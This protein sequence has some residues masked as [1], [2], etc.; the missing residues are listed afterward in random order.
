MSSQVVTGNI[1]KDVITS[2]IPEFQNPSVGGGDFSERATKAIY[3]EVVT[4]PASN[5]EDVMIRA[6]VIN[7]V[8]LT[9]NSVQLVKNNVPMADQES[10]APGESLK[11][12]ATV[13]FAD[14][15]DHNPEDPNSTPTQPY[16]LEFVLTKV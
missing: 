13:T 9:V 16:S 10:F 2:E 3:S 6:E 14:T 12:K 11:V 1:N 7:P 15:P 5:T 8:G 4:V